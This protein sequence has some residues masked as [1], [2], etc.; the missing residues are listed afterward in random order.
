MQELRATL[1]SMYQV[2]L[3]IPA[4]VCKH[5][6][7]ILTRESRIGRETFEDFGFN[8]DRFLIFVCLFFFKSDGVQNPCA[9]CN[10]S[11][12]DEC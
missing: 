6:L 1:E 11:G 2:Q 3:A 8:M 9:T 12:I 10:L 5:F 4:D 7:H